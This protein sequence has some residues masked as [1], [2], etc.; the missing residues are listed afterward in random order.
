MTTMTIERAEHISAQWRTAAGDDSP[1]G[2]L[3]SAGVF[4]EADIVAKELIIT[5]HG[6]SACT[7]S[8]TRACC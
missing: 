6:C 5:L 8:T 3:F 2:P 4:A 7:A 1:A